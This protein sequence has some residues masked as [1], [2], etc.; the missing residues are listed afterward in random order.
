MNAIEVEGL[1][2]TFNRRLRR[3]VYAV[4]GIDLEV[5]SG[6]V[7][8]FLGPNGSGKTT[9]IRCLLGLVRPDS[10]GC[11]VL[12]TSVPRGLPDVI[13]GVGSIVETPAFFPGFSARRTL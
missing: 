5:P 4:A 8:G 6:S 1:Q 3:P 12:G 7:Y 10:G 9:T 13:G 11:K 2:K